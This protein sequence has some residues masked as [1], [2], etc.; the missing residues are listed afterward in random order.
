MLSHSISLIANVAFV[1]NVISAQKQ[2]WSTYGPESRYHLWIIFL[3]KLFLNIDFIP[4][5]NMMVEGGSEGRNGD[6]AK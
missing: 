6:S 2:S 5:L 1:I 3:S 4:G